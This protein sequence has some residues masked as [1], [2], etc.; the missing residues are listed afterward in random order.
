[1]GVGG[2]SGVLHVADVLF[3]LIVI[4]GFALC[5]LVVRAIDVRVN[6]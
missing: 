5:V 6:R 1:M 2:V 4:L 3:V